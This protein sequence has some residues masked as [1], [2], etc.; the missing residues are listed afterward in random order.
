MAEF[1]GK[2]KE[3]LETDHTCTFLEP[4]LV[5]TA[6][7]RVEGQKLGVYERLSLYGLWKSDSVL[8]KESIAQTA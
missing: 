1:N 2:K 7:L 5:K 3:V 6:E 4:L 8:L